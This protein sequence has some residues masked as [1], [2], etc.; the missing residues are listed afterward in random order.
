MSKARYEQ[1]E[2][3]ESIEELAKQD[4]I[5]CRNK[6][7]PKGFFQNWSLHYCL[8]ELDLGS[9]YYANRKELIKKR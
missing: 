2:M 3:I 8:R 7:I 6:I 5:Y 4:F 9:L 1:G